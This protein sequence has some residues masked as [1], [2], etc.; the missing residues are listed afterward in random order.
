M[1]A[2]PSGGVR[3]WRGLISL[4]RRTKTKADCFVATASNDKTTLPGFISLCK[5]EYRV[6]GHRTNGVAESLCIVIA[7]TAVVPAFPRN[8]KTG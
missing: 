2:T 1:E 4:C 6:G 3:G 7:E 8:P 5:R